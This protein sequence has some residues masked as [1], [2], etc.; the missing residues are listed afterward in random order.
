MTQLITFQHTE[1]S[2]FLWHLRHAA[3]TVTTDPHY[4]LDDL[5]RLENSIEGHLDGLRIAADDG[6]ILVEDA[7]KEQ[8]G[9][10]VFTATVLVVESSSRERINKVRDFIFLNQDTHRGFCSA[11]G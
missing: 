5:L 11:L 8:E 9:G 10:E 7:L 6:W 4:D 1:E 3:V 2:A